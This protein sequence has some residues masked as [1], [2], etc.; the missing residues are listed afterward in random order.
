MDIKDRIRWIIERICREYKLT[1]ETLALIVGVSDGTVNNYRTKKNPPSAKFIVALKEK[2]S[3]NPMW[4]LIG[5]GEPYI[6]EG[7][8]QPHTE[9]PKSEK[10]DLQVRE[11]VV[12]YKNQDEK[13]G[14]LVTKTIDVL[15]S[16]TVYRS[17]LTANINAFHRLL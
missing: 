15:K 13:I 7:E 17:A 3:V 5:Q 12:E 11:P 4:L 1:N 14:D 2:Y 16:D 6:K 10:L 8:V 9:Y